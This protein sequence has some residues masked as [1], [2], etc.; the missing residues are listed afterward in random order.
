MITWLWLIEMNSDALRY[1]F[2]LPSCNGRWEVQKSLLHYYR[3]WDVERSLGLIEL[4]YNVDPDI[5]KT[6][7]DRGYYPIH[8]VW[9]SDLQSVD[10]V[11]FLLLKYPKAVMEIV[12]HDYDGEGYIIDFSWSSLEEGER[13]TVKE[14]ISRLQKLDKS[15][16]NRL[17]FSEL[18]FTEKG[19]YTQELKGILES[20]ESLQWKDG[21]A[22]LLEIFPMKETY[23]LL[24]LEQTEYPHFME[25]LGEKCSLY[26]MTK[27]LISDMTILKNVHV[28]IAGLTEAVNSAVASQL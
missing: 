22:V 23:E 6:K 11:K 9:F 4:I 10:Y 24:K 27:F 8:H 1:S 13:G 26:A 15:I 16:S 12:E 3:F 5:F 17:R 18:C 7:D 20:L 14:L 2:N 19:T 25:Y 28:D 21:Y